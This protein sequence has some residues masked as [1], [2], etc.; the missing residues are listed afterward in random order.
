M[1]DFLG[2]QNVDRLVR[3]VSRMYPGVPASVIRPKLQA[4]MSDWYS[5]QYHRY[6]KSTWELND[7]FMSEIV[8]TTPMF[9]DANCGGSR[10]WIEDG[11]GYQQSSQIN[12]ACTPDSGCVT[13][14]YLRERPDVID[15]GFGFK[16]APISDYERYM[17][18]QVIATI[19]D[20]DALI[21]KSASAPAKYAINQM[22]HR[23]NAGRCG[24]KSYHYAG[25]TQMAGERICDEVV[26]MHKKRLCGRCMDFKAQCTIPYANYGSMC[27]SAQSAS[28]TNSTI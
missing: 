9:A 15:D 5:T 17:R 23:S 10:A 4:F 3:D 12:M 21:M 14:L 19:P 6:G 13:S 18:Q 2:C 22:L 20:Q 25:A 1:C 11:C 8:M 7:L 24:T 16:G 28:I 27:S 26:A